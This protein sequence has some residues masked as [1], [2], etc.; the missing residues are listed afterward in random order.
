MRKNGSSN[1]DLCGVI[2]AKNCQFKIRSTNDWLLLDSI[3]HAWNAQTVHLSWG[4]RVW[5]WCLCCSPATFIIHHSHLFQYST[6]FQPRRWEECSVAADMMSRARGQ[7]CWRSRMTVIS[8][9]AT[10]PLTEIRICSKIYK[11]NTQHKHNRNDTDT[12]NIHTHTYRGSGTGT[13]TGSCTQQTRSTNTETG[14]HGNTQHLRRQT[15]N[16]LV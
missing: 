15:I 10:F 13:H 16:M 7:Q 8:W 6:P 5:K 11:H 12:N 14:K 2:K 1:S 3:I 9:I 4:S